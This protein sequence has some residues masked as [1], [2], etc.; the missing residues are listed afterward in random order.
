[1]IRH[2]V[3]LT[4]MLL[5]AGSCLAWGL[6]ADAGILVTDF[7]FNTVD[8]YD[9]ATGQL[10][11][12]GFFAPPAGPQEVLGLAGIAVDTAENIA[13]A[14]SRF[15]DRIYVFEATT[16]EPLVAG[17]GGTPGLFKQ[18]PAGSQPA[19]LAVDT[20]GNLYV[21]NNGGTTVDVFDRSANPIDTISDGAQLLKLPSGLTFD[22]S[23]DLFITTMAGANVLRYSG[24][25][26]SQ[27]TPPNQN[28]MPFVPNG[29]VVG[30]EGEVFVADVFSNGIF[31]YA[32]DG[33]EITADGGGPFIEIDLP[34][35]DPSP[36]HPNAPSGLA[37][38][39]DGNLLVAALGP[40]NPFDDGESHGAL[41]RLS[42]EDG[43]LL[44]EL[45]LDLPPLSN[46]ALVSIPVLGDLNLD[47]D[48]NGLDVD[49][50]VDVLLS[51]PFQVE[52]DMNKDGEVNGLDVDPFVAAV[53]GGAQMAVPEP[54]TL[55]L[56]LVAGLTLLGAR[57]R[58]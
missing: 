35:I 20:A 13:Y 9:D 2:F 48:V 28:G 54:Q 8:L 1:M 41:L 32:A 44:Q 23:G 53:V 57:R 40:T 12:T 38:D 51:G 10:I 46:L 22:E 14:S 3:R 39:E 55:L 16:G 4:A 18:L 30:P 58:R 26:L 33:T 56:A 43:S 11:E 29:V 49:P 37:F 47:G 34:G 42:S 50:F 21:A 27:F 5:I 45:G 6:R 36:Q 7:F 15:L 24:S 17:P 52:A 19:G 25:N 31:K